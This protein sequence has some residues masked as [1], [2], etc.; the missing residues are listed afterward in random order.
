MGKG[1]PMKSLAIVSGL[2]AASILS[3]QATPQPAMNRDGSKAIFFSD[4]D[5]PFTTGFRFHPESDVKVTALGAFDYLGDGL[6]TP[7]Q[8]AIW[9]A[10]GGKLLATATVTSGTT[11]PLLGA[12]RYATISDLSLTANT[13]Y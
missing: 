1:T 11:S 2:V 4:N 12:F 5:C 13:E 7:H 9:S 6:A 8:V 3:L 10:N